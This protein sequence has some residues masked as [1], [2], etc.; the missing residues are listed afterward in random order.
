MTQRFDI[1]ADEAETGYSIVNP[2]G[3]EAPA[4][5]APARAAASVRKAVS[6]AQ[7]KSPTMTAFIAGLLTG[8]IISIVSG[9]V[10]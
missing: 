10:R 1:P 3:P 6:E 5:S 2:E 8:S 4:P 9:L 7:R